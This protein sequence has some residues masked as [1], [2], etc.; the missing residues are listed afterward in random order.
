LAGGKK[1]H[2][3]NLLRG[4]DFTEQAVSALQGIP[5]PEL[6][7]LVAHGNKFVAG[8]IGVEAARVHVRHVSVGLAQSNT[9]SPVIENCG[10]E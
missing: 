10:N 4:T 8:G 1:R 6:D 7:V 3:Q 2:A 5:I 9:S